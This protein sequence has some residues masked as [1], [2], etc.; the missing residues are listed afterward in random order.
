MGSTSKTYWLS[1]S[2]ECNNIHCDYIIF[3]SHRKI[4]QFEKYFDILFDIYTGGY[5]CVCMYVYIDKMKFMC[6]V[7]RL[8]NG[9]YYKDT[10][11][12][13]SCKIKNISK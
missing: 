11:I 8:L 7:L 3:W 5:I 1:C 9:Y 4:K 6:P 12:F 10:F 13:L 2:T